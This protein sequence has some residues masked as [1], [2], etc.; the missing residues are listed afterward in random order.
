MSQINHCESWPSI[1]VAGP[2]GGREGAFCVGSRANRGVPAEAAPVVP[3]LPYQREDVES[4]ARLRW[5]C[6]A[7]QTGKSFT[8]SLRRLLRGLARKRDQVFLSAGERQCRELMLKTAQHCAALKIAAEFIED[9]SWRHLSVRR[10]EI[11][12]P[13]RVRIVGLP[14]NPRTARGFTGDVLLDEFAMHEDDRAVWAALLPTILRGDGEID[15]ASTPKGVGNVF[16][17]LSTNPAFEHSIVTLPRAVAQGLDADV[18]RMRAA[19]GDEELFRQEF[20]CEFLDES[21]RLLSVE[22]V[23]TC[24]SASCRPAVSAEELSMVSGA[25]YAGVDIGRIHDRTVI[26]I[27]SREA[28]ASPAGKPASPLPILRTTG[29]I[30]LSGAPFVRQWD[31]L[32]SVLRLANLRRCCIDGGGLGMQLCEQAVGAFGRHRV[33]AVMFT[34]ATKSGLALGLRRLIEERRIVLPADRDLAA[35]FA[36][37]RRS[38]GPTGELRL[39]A[40]RGESGHADRFWAAALAVRAAGGDEV[41]VER[42]P[43]SIAGFARTGAW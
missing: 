10:M 7:R 14:A 37:V 19:M 39:I 31:V 15:V 20:L 2:A 35:E 16:H 29:V 32:S 26:W 25:L 34:S 36:S 23:T 42:L 18:E 4:S 1:T 21:G 30:E 9:E 13:G 43:T 24:Q 12:L 33:E 8:K 22:D 38:L 40:S 28:P 41:Q 27:V 3:L 5:N 6:W 17:E 11:V